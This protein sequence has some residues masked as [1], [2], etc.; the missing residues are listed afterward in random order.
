MLRVHPQRL[1]ARWCAPEVSFFSGNIFKLQSSPEA[2]SEGDVKLSTANRFINTYFLGSA[3]TLQ[4]HSRA[5]KKQRFFA[6]IFS[7]T[8]NQATWGFTNPLC[9]FPGGSSQLVSGSQPWLVSPPKQSC[10]SSKWPFMANIWGWLLATPL[11][12]WD[13]PLSSLVKHENVQRPQKSPTTTQRDQCRLPQEFRRLR[14]GR[15]AKQDLSFFDAPKCDMVHMKCC[16]IGVHDIEKCIF[17]AKQVQ[18]SAALTKVSSTIFSS[19]AI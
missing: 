7:I 19:I 17:I 10:S 16:W 5:P 1:K 9:Y 4:D 12:K 18:H 15:R 14:W 6:R 3:F 13:D 11:T 8:E 2:S